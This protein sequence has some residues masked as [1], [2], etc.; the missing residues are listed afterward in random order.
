MRTFKIIFYKSEKGELVKAQ[1]VFRLA[2][3]INELVEAPPQEFFDMLDDYFPLHGWAEIEER[4]A[5]IFVIFTKRKANLQDIDRKDFKEW[6][7][8]V[9]P[10]DL[11]EST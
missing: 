11:S 2:N 10:S 3:S 1:E 4:R 6:L 8:S 7:E 5:T 9:N